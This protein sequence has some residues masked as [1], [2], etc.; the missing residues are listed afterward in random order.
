MRKYLEIKEMIMRLVR[1][2][3]FSGKIPGE[4]TMAAKFGFSYMTVRRAVSELA[5]EGV[6][7][8]R[9]RQGTFVSDTTM[10]FKSTG[11]VGLLLC[12]NIRNGV[13]N[14]YYSMIY[15]RLRDE[16]ASRGL[17]VVVCANANEFEDLDCLI[18]S[19]YPEAEEKIRQLSRKVPVVLIDNDIKGTS[20]P[21]VVID[22]FNSTYCA[23]EYAIN[24]GHRDIGYVAGPQ[25]SPVGIKRL[26]GF[27]TAMSDYD[28]PVN[29]KNILFGDYE[30]ASG[31]DGAG[32][33][34][35]LNKMPTYIVCAND[36]MA[37]GLISGLVEHGI[38]IPDDVSVSGF[39]N[40]EGEED[41][42][43]PMTT[44]S[45]N[46]DL[47]VKVCTDMVMSE[48]RG[49]TKVIRKYVVPAELIVRNSTS[50]PRCG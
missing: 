41:Y 23:V 33:F 48:I 14:P 21:S 49:D 38:L 29:E 4:R 47:M 13:N 43:P 26:G 10:V 45:V 20:F 39:D 30:R 37:S 18:V 24:L 19:A 27:R 5:V 8:R 1:S 44:M 22:N 25:N 50:A 34:L 32:Y 42:C 16:M 2:R 12:D 46:V 15:K 17:N 28:I 7:I 11:N 31:Y 40:T 9:P 36:C 6:L 35:S 3:E